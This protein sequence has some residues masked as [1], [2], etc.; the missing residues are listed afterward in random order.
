MGP[1]I[2]DPMFK[3]DATL[4]ERR[5]EPSD[6]PLDNGES[7]LAGEPANWVSLGRPTSRT[8]TDT[9]SVNVANR[10]PYRAS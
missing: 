7:L 4:P 5:S 8:R 10:W 2:L 9:S 3:L 1:S 6:W